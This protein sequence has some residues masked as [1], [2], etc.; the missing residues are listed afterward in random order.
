[1]TSGMR[2]VTH[3]AWKLAAVVRGTATPAV[4]AS[5]DA[6]RRPHATE[7]V[8]FAAKIGAMY[9]PRN[10]L[11]ERLRDLVFRAVQIVPGGRDYILQMKYKPMP[12]Y[13]AGVVAGVQESNA[14][15]PV[16]KMFPQPDVLAPGGRM[17]LDDAIGPWFAV[18]HLGKEIERLDDE[19]AANWRRRGARVV[20]VVAANDRRIGEPAR[21][22]DDGAVLTIEDV[23]GVFR[24]WRLARPAD[25][26]IILRPDR[27]V[28]ATCDLAGFAAT[29][30]ALEATL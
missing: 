3:L 29:T 9:R 11:T 6:E 20:H 22:G 2:D 13:T 25:E 14:K 24:D 19:T 17:K 15:D 26:I 30:T 7:M 16:G 23:D 1:M 8:E 10:L 27:Y 18:L 5:Y 4:L 28:A 12:R 21:V